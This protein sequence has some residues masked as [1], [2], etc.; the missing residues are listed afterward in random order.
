MGYALARSGWVR[1]R[2]GRR[3]R[4]K[5]LTR[6]LTGHTLI[7]SSC[8][9]AADL[10]THHRQPGYLPPFR[11]YEMVNLTLDLILLARYLLVPKG[12]LV[13][14]L[15]TVTE[16]YSAIDIPVVEGMRE[17]KFGEGS[18]QNFG[19]WGR[20]VGHAYLDYQSRV[21]VT[22]LTSD[23]KLITMEKTAVD[24]GQPPEFG[25][26]ETEMTR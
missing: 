24:D 23:V 14:F 5:N 15:P 16:E 17:L 1:K 26:H 18:V 8:P 25:D 13:F 12:R 6:F 7:C 2:L 20:R 19:K 9:P 21:E 3:P 4:L 11:P 22:R 10:L